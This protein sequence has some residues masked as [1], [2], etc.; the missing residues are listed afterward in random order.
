MRF[1]NEV[2]PGFPISVFEFPGS[3]LFQVALPAVAV[4]HRHTAAHEYGG[5]NQQKKDAF[6]DRALAAFGAGF[7]VARTHRAALAE[8]RRG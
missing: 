3:A 4:G 7:Y 6:V 2:F 1:S 8:G 5:G